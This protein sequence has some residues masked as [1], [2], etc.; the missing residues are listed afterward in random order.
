MPACEAGGAASVV[1][2][3]SVVIGD[4]GVRWA[5]VRIGVLGPLEV[6][7]GAATL[8]TRSKER[9]VL[10]FLALR[11]G[12][13]A[14]VADLLD[15]LWGD[16]PPATAVRSLQECVA[17]VRAALG[18]EAVVATADGYRLTVAADDVDVVRFEQGL[19]SASAL[20]SEG[21][22]VECVAVL[23]DAMGLWRA[24]P[25][26][27]LSESA[28]ARAEAARLRARRDTA[29]ED[30]LAAR[31]A[32][33]D[34][35]WAV[36]EA[37]R[38]V[39]DAPSS[40]RRWTLLALALH[41]AD[42]QADALHACRRARATLSAELRAGDE[43][44]AVEAGVAGQE[45]DL[46]ART[47]GIEAGAAATRGIGR[48]SDLPSGTVTFVLTDIEDSTA[49]W[50]RAPGD[51]ATA[52]RRHDELV[53]AVIATAGGV[54][55]KHKGE[56]DSTMSVTDTAAA[57]VEA[58]V[59]LQQALAAESWPEA[60]PIRVRVA[61]STGEVELRDGDYFGPA[62]NRAARIRSVATGGQIV[63]G[64]TTHALVADTLAEPMMVTSLGEH[65]LKGLS[66][67][68][69]VWELRVV[70]AGSPP[71]GAV[72]ATGA[73][74]DAAERRPLAVEFP[75]LLASDS[76]AFAG[77]QDELGSLVD[78]WHQSADGVRRSVLISGEPGIGKTRLAAEA[79][80]VAHDEGAVV[81]YGRCDEDLAVPFQPFA[82]A[83]DHLATRSV[84]D[85][86]ARLG[87][88]PGELL[89]LAP[90]LDDVVAGLERPLAADPDT[91]RYRLCGAVASPVAALGGERSAV[92][93]RDD[94][95]WASKPTLLLLRHVLRTVP[96]ARL[97][98]IGT[99]RD[100]DIDRSHPL[101]ELLADL[102]R[103]PDVERLALDG[104]TPAEVEAYVV[105]AAGHQLDDD[106]RALAAV[107]HGETSGN[108]FFVGEVLRHLVETGA[109]QRVAGQWR[110]GPATTADALPEG[111][112]DVIGRRLNQL[113]PAANEVAVCAAVIGR[114]FGLDVLV[115]VASR[116]ES[117]VLDALDEVLDVRLVEETAPDRYRFSHALVRATL[118]E[119]LRSS[120]R[121]R[122]HRTVG[123][124]I[125]RR[126]P[127]DLSALAHHFA[128]AAPAGE[129]PRAVRYTVA[130]AERA[131]AQLAL[132]EAAELH[133]RALDLFDDG[134]DGDIDDGAERSAERC[135]LLLGLATAQRLAGGD[136]ESSLADATALAR[137]LRDGE[138]L[139]RCALLPNKGWNSATFT[140]NEPFV[141]LL[142]EVLDVLEDGDSPTRALVLATLSV[143]LGFSGELERIRST[144]DEAVAMAERLEL[145]ADRR[146][147]VLA[148]ALAS[149]Q[150][151]PDLSAQ[152]V[153]DERLAVVRRLQ[154]E[155]TDPVQREL[156]AWGIPGVEAYSGR[157]RQAASAFPPDAT[158]PGPQ[159]AWTRSFTLA[160]AALLRGDHDDVERLIE[161]GLAHGQEASDADAWVM[162][163]N[164]MLYLRR[165]QGRPAEVVP[166]VQ[167]AIDDEMP[168]QWAWNAA[169][170]ML[171]SEAGQLDEARGPLAV[172]ATMYRDRQ[173]DL[174]LL[175]VGAMLAAATADLDDLDVA[176][177]LY[178]QLRPHAGFVASWGVVSCLGPVSLSLGRLAS[179]LGWTADADAHLDSAVAWARDQGAEYHLAEA[180]LYRATNLIDRGAPSDD[181]LA[182]V[183]LD[184]CRSIAGPRDFA[185]I[186]GRAELAGGTHDRPHQHR[187]L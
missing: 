41:S 12:R 34:H 28:E 70:A 147:R 18:R 111:V 166:L 98:V 114:D 42:R 143:E 150:G 129:Y 55:L 32:L 187:Q 24:A 31:L 157:H 87:D 132:A 167:Q 155:L 130:A 5:P 79:A 65:D 103:E 173:V 66:R 145:D 134:I 19:D 43:L 151:W 125:E 36:A 109:V 1:V 162:W 161:E 58:A 116:P 185:T 128:E 17:G 74:P 37:E 2:V 67:P 165:Q 107:V 113:S 62:V 27:E 156:I 83:I 135:E 22:I 88:M 104:L 30:R 25:W 15:A 13:P 64:A 91:E 61:V 118:Y 176:G 127:D 40:E 20:W 33:G 110:L 159:V 177:W 92:R 139:A 63:L 72:A 93:V 106:A 141:A 6:G 52:L 26:P 16:D 122:L 35:D 21:R 179:R 138:R 23:D 78:R 142:E 68:E 183:L 160:G 131:R 171:R 105:A 175:P 71:D 50:D 154:S 146:V 90:R 119:E 47:L 102:R 163:A 44:G 180:L 97:V 69:H 10:A 46:V 89:R 53:A 59:Q 73:V 144:G 153:C 123:E 3:A 84:G 174:S 169:L 11:A 137:A 149:T 82:E 7:G 39:A 115:D 124:S 121:V 86:A 54:L 60:C 136:F 148:L 75:E 140:V 168:G 172:A 81:L 57:G 170:A 45:P 108:P 94:L 164:Q 14:S 101:S 126:R 181:A 76:A 100:T 48:V 8:P 99:Y 186:V 4:V 178:E 29:L 95:H 182:T 38:L 96:R 158:V 51:M 9:S 80:R 85:L 133:R 184:E 120:R 49:L 77:R 56:G 112:R 117:E 152:T